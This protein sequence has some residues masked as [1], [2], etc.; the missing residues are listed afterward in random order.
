MVDL[1]TDSPKQK[2]FGNGFWVDPKGYAVTCSR[3]RDS[4]LIVGTMMPRIWDGKS[5]SYLAGVKYTWGESAYY[6]ADTGVEVVRVYDNPFIR[7]IHTFVQHTPW[8]G[9]TEKYW[10]ACLSVGRPYVGE[11][12][13]LAAAEPNRDES[14]KDKDS[15]ESVPEIELVEGKVT[16]LGDGTAPRHWSSLRIYTSLPSKPWCRGAPVL[17]TSRRVIGLVSDSER[18]IKATPYLC[19]QSTSSRF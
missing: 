1:E 17:D 9:I 4:P 16:S 19:L 14:D 5:T 7:T 11:P 13:F 2:L 18:W 6:D 15:G 10:T 8:N 3:K 12:I